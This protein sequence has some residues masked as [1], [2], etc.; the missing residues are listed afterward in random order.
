MNR[1]AYRIVGV[2]A[3]QAGLLHA[4]DKLDPAKY[5]VHVHVS[6]AQYSVHDA[7]SQVLSVVIDGK[8]YELAGGTSSAKLYS[9]SGNGLL[10]PG[11]YVAR[12]TRDEHK[13]PYESLQMYELLFP[14]GKVRTFTV[15]LQG[16]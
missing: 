15:I 3:L 16:E 13:T 1:W 7:M 10:N 4:A 6:A 9:G 11:D 12:L 2:C 8:H 5:T 14:D